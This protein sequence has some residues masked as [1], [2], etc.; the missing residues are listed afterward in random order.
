MIDD[1]VMDLEA[2][3]TCGLKSSITTGKE[4]WTTTMINSGLILWYEPTN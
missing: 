2:I 1:H 4:C 3:S